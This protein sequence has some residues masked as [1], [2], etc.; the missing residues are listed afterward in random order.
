MTATVLVIALLPSALSFTAKL[1][2]RV[3]AVGFSDMFAYVT[4]RRAVWNSARV[5][6]LPA[7]DKVNTPVVVLKFAVILPMPVDA[8]SAKTS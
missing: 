6:V 8:E 7:D 5:A 3:P 1:I 2:V 4:D